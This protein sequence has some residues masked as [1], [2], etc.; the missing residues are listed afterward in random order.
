M[1]L[2]YTDFEN[3]LLLK[4]KISKNIDQNA[5]RWMKITGE[6]QAVL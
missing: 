1:L 4:V 3:T 5:L 2:M 6:I